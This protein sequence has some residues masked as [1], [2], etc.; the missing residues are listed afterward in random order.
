MTKKDKGIYAGLD[1]SLIGTGGVVLDKT[2]KFLNLLAFT[3][4]KKEA[5]LRKPRHRFVLTPDDCKTQSQVWARTCAAARE[6]RAWVEENTAPDCLIGIED[7]AFS[8]RG[9][10]MY[11]LGH[12]HG[13]VRR[14]LQDLG[15]KWIL[16]APTVLKKAVTGKGTADKTQMGAVPI[17]DL[18]LAEFHHSSA[19]NIV[20]AYWLARCAHAFG[21]VKAGRML[22]GDCKDSIAV[23]LKPGKLRAGL[24]ANEVLP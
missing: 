7:H 22:L 20:D 3:K 1:L 17:R 11:Q 16:V 23:A 15:R 24:L 4:S 21:E 5:A 18:N 13:L 10:S 12:L 14:D 9:T 8:A 6:I 19:H 2:G